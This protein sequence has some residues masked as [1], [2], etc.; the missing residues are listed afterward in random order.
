MSIGNSLNHS[1][2]LSSKNS[3]HSM[4]DTAGT[5][6]AA[7]CRRDCGSAVRSTLTKSTLYRFVSTDATK[8][9]EPT[10]ASGLSCLICRCC[11][12][13]VILGGIGTTAPDT[14]LNNPVPRRKLHLRSECMYGK[15]QGKQAS[16]YKREKKRKS[17]TKKTSARKAP[18]SLFL[19][20][21]V[22]HVCL[23]KEKCSMN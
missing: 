8:G 22:S 11:G 12:A 3:S 15:T 23:C 16:E 9:R 13:G 21:S 1:G 20:V 7:T 19:S 18:L 6:V 17:F 5:L 2:L 14:R 10:Y 4:R